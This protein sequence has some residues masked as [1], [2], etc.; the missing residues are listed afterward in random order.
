VSRSER[1]KGAELRDDLA[2]NGLD[3][4]TTLYVEFLA[5]RER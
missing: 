3:A 4:P 1:C 2:E 5:A